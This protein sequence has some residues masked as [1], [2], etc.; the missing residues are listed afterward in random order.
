MRLPIATPPCILGKDNIC[1]VEFFVVVTVILAMLIFAFA[2]RDK[3]SAGRGST[4]FFPPVLML[5]D[6]MLGAGWSVS[7]F[8][9][10][11]FWSSSGWFLYGVDRA[12]ISILCASFGLLF[13]VDVLRGPARWQRGFGVLFVFHFVAAMLLMAVAKG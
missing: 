12:M 9:L 6:I 7:I 13:A 4:A 2:K 10:H 8:P 11:L 3:A 1:S 5:V